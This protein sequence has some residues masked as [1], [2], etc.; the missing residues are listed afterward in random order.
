[1]IGHPQPATPLECEA[2]ERNPAC[3]LALC[4]AVRS[5]AHEVLRH[6]V[7]DT[8]SPAESTLST[9]AVALPWGCRVRI[10]CHTTSSLP[11][12][13]EEAARTLG[14]SDLEVFWNVTLPNIR[15]GLMYGIIL[16]NAVRCLL[17]LLPPIPSSVG[18]SQRPALLLDFALHC[19]ASVSG[20]PVLLQ[21]HLQALLSIIAVCLLPLVS[22]RV[23]GTRTCACVRHES[24]NCLSPIGTA[25][26]CY[27]C[28]SAHMSGADT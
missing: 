4:C 1:M 24:G 21:G 16:T 17:L 28:Y 20:A 10:T 11:H 9:C 27:R 8:S 2:D 15:W 6:A 22:C 13:Q 23:A 18:Q 3:C 19:A 25:L 12:K 26:F 7:P 5:S 14:A